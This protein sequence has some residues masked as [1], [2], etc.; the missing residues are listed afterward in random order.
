M[1]GSR[2][3]SSACRKR[4]TRSRPS[5]SLDHLA[6]TKQLEGALVTIDAMGCQ[7]EIADMIVAHKA[8]FMLALKG[9]Q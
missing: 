8:D 4:P 1:P 7:V 5:P 9:D 6:D 3:R 2:W